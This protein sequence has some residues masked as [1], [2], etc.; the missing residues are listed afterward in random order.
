MA[1]VDVTHRSSSPRS[2]LP[3]AGWTRKPAVL[4]RVDHA[5]DSFRMW[6]ISSSCLRSSSPMAS[7]VRQQQVACLGLS[8]GWAHSG[9]AYHYRR[10]SRRP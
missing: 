1:K 3:G 8:G 4:M 9:E 6:R 10:A 5:S 7:T 2:G